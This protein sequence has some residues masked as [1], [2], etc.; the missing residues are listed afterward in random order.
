MTFLIVLGVISIGIGIVL[1]FVERNQSGRAFSLRSA[2][3]ATVAELTQLAQAVSQDMGS[4]SWRDYVKVMGT[5]ECDRPLYSELTQETCVYY[6]MTVKREYEETVTHTDDKGDRHTDVQRGSEV[7]SSNTRSTPFWVNDGTG[8]IEVNP[9]GASIDAEPVLDDFR[10]EGAKGDLISYGSFSLAASHPQSGRRTLGYRYTESL[11]PVNRRVLVV[12]TVS[13]Q[14][15]SLVLQ[16][17]METGQCFI[18]SLK[19][20]EALIA[21]SDRTAKNAALWMKICIAVGAI[22]ILISTLF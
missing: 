8:A 10:N 12:G 14:S 13:D 18:V 19:T 7:L 9:N 15:G 1:Y 4:G 16:K 21:E 6:S 11:L 22:L 17:P 20:D 3:P 5:I 2:K